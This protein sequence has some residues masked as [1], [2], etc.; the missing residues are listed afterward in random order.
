MET[1]FCL[2]CGK[3]HFNRLFSALDFDSG[4]VSFE[5]IEC[6]NCHLVRANPV[7]IHSELEKYYNLPYYGSG[8]DKFIGLAEMLTYCSNYLRYCSILSHLDSRK[9]SPANTPIKIIDIGCGR[10]HLLKILQQKGF[11][12]YGI[13]RANFPKSDE[14]ENIHIYRQK[15]EDV[16]FSENFFDVVLIWHV[17]E[18][19]DDPVS[20]IR[21]AVRIL[22]PGGLLAL[23]VPN[24][25]SNQARFFRENW[26]HLDLPRHIHHFTK[27]V[28]L[29]LL[30]AN[31]FDIMRNHT[32]SIEQ[33]LFGFMQSFF[34]KMAP[35]IKPNKFYSLLK[36]TRGPSSTISLIIW[37]TFALLIFPF[38]LLEYLISGTIGKGATVIIYAKKC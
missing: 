13:E 34:N 14:A 30:K 19:A 15:I 28:L 22:R 6:E 18:H 31:G 33:N 38:A 4:K 24:F 23:A 12:C 25:G 26:F 17:L 16:G 3:N 10:G 32:F 21:E 7:P 8:T 5:L 35:F 1:N 20:A 29:G 37:T 9:K 11:D 27:D 2:L 36:K